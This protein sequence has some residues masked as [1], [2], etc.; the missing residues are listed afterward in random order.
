MFTSTIA[1]VACLN[2][3]GR[4]DLKYFQD[5]FHDRPGYEMTVF[6]YGQ[7]LY[8]RE[9]NEA[10]LRR[11]ARMEERMASLDHNVTSRSADELTK[12]QEAAIRCVAKRKLFQPFRVNFE[13]ADEVKAELHAHPEEYDLTG[14][15]KSPRGRRL[16][17]E[18]ANDQSGYARSRLRD[19]DLTA[20]FGKRRLGFTEMCQLIKKRLDLPKL[21]ANTGLTV[22]LHRDFVRQ[23]RDLLYERH[24]MNKGPATSNLD[25]DEEDQESAEAAPPRKRK[26]GLQRPENGQDFFSLMTSYMRAKQ[27]MYGKEVGKGDSW[28]ECVFSI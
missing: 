11:L 13:H 18:Y 25:D 16:V 3:S 4:V 8:L 26:R 7:L 23:H 6:L 5:I 21:D 20:E 9:N 14:L 2:S 27:K 12:D 10:L 19:A 1:D 15:L 17:E 22:L 28:H 24:M